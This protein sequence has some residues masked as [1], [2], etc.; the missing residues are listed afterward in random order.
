MLLLR[1]SFRSDL[2]EWHGA[3]G[4]QACF[5]EDGIPILAS[6]EA[7][8]HIQSKSPR[9]IPS[10]LCFPQELAAPLLPTGG[11]KANSDSDCHAWLCAGNSL[12]EAD[13]AA[14][15][16]GKGSHGPVYGAGKRF[17]I[18]GGDETVGKNSTDPALPLGAS[19]KV[20][21]ARF[22]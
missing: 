17:E 12:L 15:K 2:T 14:Q 16:Q 8:V 13:D 4:W 10:G 7:Y 1:V 20:P 18:P 19:H 11:I 5:V 3:G 6:L 9:T 22:E 21:F